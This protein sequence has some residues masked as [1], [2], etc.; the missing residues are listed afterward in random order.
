MMKPSAGW[1]TCGTSHAMFSFFQGVA[2][3]GLLCYLGQWSAS[4]HHQPFSV[5]YG[6]FVIVSINVTS[7]WSENATK[8]NT[9]ER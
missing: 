6:F 4:L 5:G 9:T 8:R 7:S 2:R 1:T 3:L